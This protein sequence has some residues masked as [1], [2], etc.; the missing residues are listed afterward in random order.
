MRIHSILAAAA[1]GLSFT[2]A[3]LAADLKPIQDQAIDLGGVAGDAYYTVEPDGFHVVATFAQR[4]ASATPMR[5]ET[6]LSSGQTVTFSTPRAAGVAPV[7]VTLT[8]QNGRV[9]VSETKLIN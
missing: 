2:G 1:F 5:F 4:D 7:G 6:V 3:A 9:L 8:R